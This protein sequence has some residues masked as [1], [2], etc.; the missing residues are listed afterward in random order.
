LRAHCHADFSHPASGLPDP[1][2]EIESIQKT[3]R[4]AEKTL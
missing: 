2:A 4:H 1:A 3:A